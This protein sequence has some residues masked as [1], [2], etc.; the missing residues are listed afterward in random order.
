M[1][2]GCGNKAATTKP[3]VRVELSWKGDGSLVPASIVARGPKNEAK[4]LP[5]YAKLGEDK[6]FPCIDRYG[7]FRWLDWPGKIH[8]DEDFAQRLAHQSHAA[9]DHKE[10]Y[11]Q[12]G[13]EHREH[14]AQQPGPSLWQAVHH[15][16]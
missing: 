6:F 15:A 3:V 1:K 5:P 13:G 7:Q 11:G 10:A 2:N 12:N 8:G 14:I 9:I 4:D 16:A